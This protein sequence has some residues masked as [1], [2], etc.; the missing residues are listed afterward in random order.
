M[1]D[2]TITNDGTTVTARTPYHPDFPKKA[3]AIGG[4]FRGGAWTFDARDEQRVRDLCREIYGT[5]GTPVDTVT[6]RISTS[7]A[8]D[9][10][11]WWAFGRMIAERRYRDSAVRLGD[12][13]VIVAGGFPQRGGSMKYP[14]LDA[15][16]GT[17]L[18]IRD[19][20]AGHPD[21]TEYADEIEIVPTGD[22][23]TP[24]IVTLTL[25]ADLAAAL[26]KAR[27]GDE[28]R[29]DAIRRILE[30]ALQ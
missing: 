25:P 8:P 20:P 23:D 22:Q 4:K 6:V 29:E 14:R 24:A 7:S 5:D 10:S 1:A 30:T 18:E 13:V 28:T 19:V 26:D 27:A 3:R 12:G 9:E 11:A 21:L 16:E 15:Y 2:I 17:I